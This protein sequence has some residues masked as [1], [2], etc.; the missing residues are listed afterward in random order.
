MPERRLDVLSVH[1]YELRTAP[2]VAPRWLSAA[3]AHLPEALPLRF[4]ESEPLRGRFDRDGDAGFLAAAERAT[5]LLAVMG[6]PPVHAASLAA[7]PMIDRWGPV[8]SHTMS[9]EVDPADERVR[10]FALALTV[11]ETIYVSAST[12]RDLLLDRRTLVHIG[13]GTREPHLAALGD[14]LGLP[15][16]PPQW[17]WFGPPYRRLGGL[18]TGGEWVPERYRARLDEVDPV[19][20]HAPRIPRGLRRRWLFGK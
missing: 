12:D 15:P 8:Q 11:P 18:W 6:G 13:P 2:A 20:R 7:T 5:G 16:T 3:R 19:R 10:A 9:V 14:W 17:C 1:W 4:G